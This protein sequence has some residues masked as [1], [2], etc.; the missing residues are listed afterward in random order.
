MEGAAISYVPSILALPKLRRFELD[1]DKITFKELNV[2]KD[3][4]VPSFLT[5]EMTEINAIKISQKSHTFNSYGKGIKLIKDNIKNGNVNAQIFHDQ[6]I[7]ELSIL[8]DR[9]GYVSENGNNGLI[10]GT[11]PN[12]HTMSSAEIPALSGD[13]FTQILKAKQIATAL[14]I[15]VNNYTASSNLTVYFYGAELLA[16]LGNITA[17]QENDV[18]YHI[19]QAFADKNV[20][21][22]DVSELAVPANLSLGNGIIVVS[23]DLTLVEHCGAPTLK[24]DGVN[25]EDDYY[26]ARYYMGSIQIRPE[27]Y[28][29]VIKQA[30]TFAS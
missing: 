3:S 6:T 24:N 9:A 26:W 27:V 25:E 11:D 28:G 20:K 1:S 14:N 18:R 5:S 21:F 29:A 7:R 8:F 15:A 22:L 30:I 17:G 13:G 16:F 19:K 10:N 12:L 2:E 23:D 4:I